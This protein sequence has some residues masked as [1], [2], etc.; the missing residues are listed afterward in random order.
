MREDDRTLNLFKPL[1]Q[2]A[3]E[4]F[5]VRDNVQVGKRVH[6]SA[7]AQI[8]GVLEPAGALPVIVEDDVLVGGGCG[9]D[10]GAIVRRGAVLYLP[11]H[12][13]PRFTRRV[14]R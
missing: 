7:A 1:L 2:R 6:L 4:W 5:A 8:G 3:Y 13:I 14:F 12:A 9:V 10:E 11:I